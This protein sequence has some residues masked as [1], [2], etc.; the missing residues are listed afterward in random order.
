MEK[1]RLGP[2]SWAGFAKAFAAFFVI[3]WLRGVAYVWLAG[4]E[5]PQIAGDA[6][7]LGSWLL[8]AVLAWKWMIRDPVQQ[9]AKERAPEGAHDVSEG[10]GA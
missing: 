7:W 6:V 8:W 5:A 4:A 10:G 1:I 9:Q 3:A 2:W